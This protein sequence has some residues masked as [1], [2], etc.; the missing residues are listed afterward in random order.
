MN[1]A[2]M[3]NLKLKSLVSY[4]DTLKTRVDLEDLGDLLRD[5]DLQ[6]SD[7]E[8]FLHFKESCYNRVPVKSSQWYDLLV[9]CWKPGQNSGIH[10]HGGSSCGFKILN[11][12]AWE[13]VFQNVSGKDGQALAQKSGERHYTLGSLCLAEDN[14]IHRIE[15]RSETENLVTLHIYS[16][17]LQMNSYEEARSENKE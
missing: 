1:T 3:A 2:E 15:N 10:D 9:I 8:E 13:S 4:L 6:L 12:E 14:D 5:L 7:V 16:P 11:G 17:A